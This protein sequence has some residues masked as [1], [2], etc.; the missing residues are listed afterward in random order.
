MNFIT[1]LQFL[2]L[3]IFLLTYRL[4]TLFYPVGDSCSWQIAFII[5]GIAALIQTAIFLY[6]KY[7]LNP[8]ILT[9]NCFLLCGGIGMTFGIKI[10]LEFYK[11]FM[12]TTLLIWLLIVG[13]ITTIFSKKGFVGVKHSSHTKIITYSLILVGAAGLAVIWSLYFK[14]NFFLSAFVPFAAVVLLR[15]VLMSVVSKN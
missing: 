4:T 15:K 1:A 14:N 10:I 9:V 2:P 6:K 8:V 11:N 5:G 13:I 3:S 7:E 12:Q